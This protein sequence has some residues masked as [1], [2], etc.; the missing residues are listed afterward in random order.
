MP[1]RNPEL[2]EGTDHVVNGAMQTGTGG[3]GGGGTGGTTDSGSFVASGSGGTA[4]DDTGGTATGIKN[5]LRQGAQSLKS[6]ATGKAREY[7]DEGKGRATGALDDLARIVRDTAG[8]VDEKFGQQYGDYVR[9]AADAVSDFSGSIRNKDVDELMTDARDV[10]RK[11]PAVAVGAAAAVGFV[12]VRL[13]KAGLE[14]AGNGERTTARSGAA[15]NPGSTT[16]T[17]A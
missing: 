15:S 3:G 8:E 11:S 9:K 6:Q 4:T 12:L 1:A 7:A 5:Q 13:V 10:I 17:G 16:G 2:P 14:E